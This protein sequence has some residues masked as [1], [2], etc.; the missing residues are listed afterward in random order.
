MASPLDPVHPVLIVGAGPCGL[1]L[2]RQLRRLGVPAHI[3]E[4]ADRVA[5]PWRSRH[6]RLRLNTHRHY[7]H[8]PGRALP[9]EAGDFAD[10]DAV[11]RY[12]ERYAQDLG[13]PIEY[14]ERVER[15]DPLRGIWRVQTSNGLR[16]ARHVVV[17]TGRERVPV[18][19]DW[20]GAQRFTGEL[21]HAADFGDAER[22]RDRRVLV[23]GCGNSGVDVLNHLVRIPIRDLRVSVR[24]GPAILPTRLCGVPVQRLS[25][26]MAPLPL[27]LVD[28]LLSLTEHLAFGDLRRLGLPRHH[29]GAATRHL[30]EGIAPAFDDGFVAALKAGRVA[31]LPAVTRF[32]GADVVLADGQRVQPDV[33]I[34]ATGYRPGLEGMLGHLGVLDDKGIPR[35]REDAVRD[36]LRGLWFSGMRPHLQGNF[37][38]AAEAGRRLAK[39]M[40]HALKT[41]EGGPSAK[42]RPDLHDA[43]LVRVDLTNPQR[44]GRWCAHARRPVQ[45]SR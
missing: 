26:L 1:A 17:A 14:G 35:A 20:P 29:D 27:P 11:I 23:V 39:R 42:H 36:R 19:P 45:R 44:K 30:R 8:L 18:M 38:A 31:P 9:R 16:H 21:I 28:L 24:H 40:H 41:E 33:V 2:G 15:L 3:V 25:G 12:L 13:V 7:S 4:A 6:P 34:C 5:E 43:A 10:R 32:D 22:Y 37:H